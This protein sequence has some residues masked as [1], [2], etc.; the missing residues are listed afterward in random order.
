MLYDRSNATS[1]QNVLLFGKASVDFRD[2][3]GTASNFIPNYQGSCPFDKNKCLSTDDFFVK[4]DDGEGMN[5]MGT[6]DAGIGRFPVRTK[7][8]AIV[9]QNEELFI[10]KII[11]NYNIQ[12]GIEFCRLEKCSYFLCR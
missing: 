4:L 1:P 2:R 3:T 11:V 5:N 10:T 9:V 7:T 6:M 12:F 8:Q